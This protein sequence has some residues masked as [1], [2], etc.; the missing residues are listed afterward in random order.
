VFTRMYV[1]SFL[2]MALIAGFLTAFFQNE[3]SFRDNFEQMHLP[4][5]ELGGNLNEAQQDLS[6]LMQKTDE[7]GQ[8]IYV[9]NQSISG[10]RSILYEMTETI[11]KQ[12]E[13][14]ALQKTKIETLVAE[15]KTQREKSFDLL[16]QILSNILGE[17]IGQTFGKNAA[18]KV[19]TLKEAGY[20]GYMAKVRLHNPN[21]VKLVL[22][23]D[24]VGDPGEKTSEAAK[25]TDAVLALNGGGFATTQDGLLYPMGITVVDGEIKTFYRTDLSFIGFDGQGKLVG[26]EITTREQVKQLGV[27]QGATFV[28]TL[29]KDGKKMPIPK[30]WQN[31]KEPRTLIGHFSNGD[32]LFIVI[33]GRQEGYSNGVTLE[34]AQ[35]KLIEFNV[36]DAYNLDGGGSSAFYYDGKIL[37]SPSDGKERRLASNFVILP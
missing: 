12:K 37:N 1:F 6:G 5:E 15:S 7:T 4:V 16:D 2:F 3:P 36:R 32:L 28:P 13:E 29:L 8:T 22:A 11:S 35:K 19:F 31:K 34:E 14:Y 21:A 26:G 10:I 18:I 17:P 24:K 23:H 30:K 25:R 33:D 27:T 9:T 20:R